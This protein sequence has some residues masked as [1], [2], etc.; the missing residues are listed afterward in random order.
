MINAENKVEHTD[1][2]HTDTDNVDDLIS[3]LNE[4]TQPE[5]KVI[6]IKPNAP[7]GAQ[8][9]KPVEPKPVEPITA[10]KAKG[11]AQRWVKTFSSGLKLLFTA[12]YKSSILKPGDAEK[13]QELVRQN[14]GKS[15]KEIFDAINANDPIYDV[16][17]RFEKYMK[18][19]DEIPLS[20]DE[21]DSI[22]EPLEE[23]IVKYKALQ[24]T[25]EWMLVIS[26][27]LVMLP[28]VVPIMPDLSK[29]FQP[30]K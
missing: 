11:M 16:S 28:R 13:M 12:V 7:A 9:D 14:K 3:Q 24:L 8:A 2:E 20:Q 29:I 23:L 27:G 1:T 5:A 4:S 30:K 26:V 18:A 10:A 21:I 22:A 25:P 6:E 19:V 17:N 15:D